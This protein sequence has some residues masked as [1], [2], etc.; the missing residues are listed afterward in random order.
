MNYSEL[1]KIVD[2]NINVSKKI[3]I[4]NF[5]NCKDEKMKS[6]RISLV[7]NLLGRYTVTL[8]LDYE[9]GRFTE[10]ETFTNKDSAADYAW[11]LFKNLK[12]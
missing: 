2:T 5:L 3:Y 4:C 9:Y 1:K 7:K 10:Q 6:I 8:W 11:Q 12:I